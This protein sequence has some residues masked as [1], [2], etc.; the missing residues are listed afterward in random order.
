MYIQKIEE[1]RYLFRI[2]NYVCLII[3][4]SDKINFVCHVLWKNNFYCAV[5]YNYTVTTLNYILPFK[6]TVQIYNY[7]V[8]NN[9]TVR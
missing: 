8:N 9:Y 5:L 7:N 1:E 2:S 6:Y 4:N 3:Y